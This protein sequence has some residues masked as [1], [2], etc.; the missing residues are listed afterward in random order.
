V[1]AHGLLWE[2]D[3]AA[4]SQAHSPSSEALLSPIP[5]P[6]LRT[7]PPRGP[8]GFHSTHTYTAAGDQASQQSTAAGGRGSQDT[9][10]ASPVASQ[11]Q[12]SIPAQRASSMELQLEPTAAAVGQPNAEAADPASAGDGTP[13]HSAWPLPA[14]APTPSVDGGGLSPHTAAFITRAFAAREKLA[15]QNAVALE[16]AGPACGQAAGAEAAR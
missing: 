9:G 16:S 10:A 3:H 12:A 1:D 4:G 13:M 7:L 8:S 15:A 14:E 5:F 11:A 2:I 6:T